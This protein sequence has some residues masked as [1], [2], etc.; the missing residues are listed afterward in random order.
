MKSAS[1]KERKKR[2]GLTLGGPVLVIGREGSRPRLEEEALAGLVG[3]MGV[4]AKT[5]VLPLQRKGVERPSNM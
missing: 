2:K 3:A 1:E 4:L 5:A